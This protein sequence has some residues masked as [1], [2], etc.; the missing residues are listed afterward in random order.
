MQRLEAELN[1]HRSRDR[2]RGAKASDALDERPKGE[3]DQQDL[4]ARIRGH[5]RQA[6]AEYVEQPAFHRQLVKK[7]D[8]DK[9]PTDRKQT[10]RDAVDRTGPSQPAGHVID[11]QRDGQGA[12][13]TEQRGEVDANPQEG[14]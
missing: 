11:P 10:V 7:D 2:D 3:G 8:V 4:D 9:N 13:Q 14:D 5:P 6:L 12:A 1:Q